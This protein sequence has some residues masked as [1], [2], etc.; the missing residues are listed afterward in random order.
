MKTN[1]YSNITSLSSSS[2]SAPQVI[3]IKSCGQHLKKIKE[4]KAK[5]HHEAGYIL[6]LTVQY[7]DKNKDS[8]Y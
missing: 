5:R 6:V 3:F 2:S 7:T 1:Y 4:L 8:N